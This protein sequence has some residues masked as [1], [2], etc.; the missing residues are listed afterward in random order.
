MEH[1]ITKAQG[2]KSQIKAEEKETNK[3]DAQSL[4]EL[5]E[6]LQLFRSFDPEKLSKAILL[7]TSVLYVLGLVT[8]N[9]YLFNFGLSEFSLLKAQYIYTG[10]L[11][12]ILP[13]VTVGCFIVISITIVGIDD[14]FFESFTDKLSNKVEIDK[15]SNELGIRLTRVKIARVLMF[16][17]IPFAIPYLISF[18]GQTLSWFNRLWLTVGLCVLA[19]LTSMFMLVTFTFVSNTS[20]LSRFTN[21]ISTFHIKVVYAMSGA[22][23]FVPAFI[24]YQGLMIE[25][26]YPY[27]PQQFGGGQPVQCQLQLKENFVKQANELGILFPQEGTLTSDIQIIFEGNNFYVLRLNDTRIIHLNKDVVI[28]IVVKK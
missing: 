18:G 20:L 25:Y 19:F 14:S 6:N 10:A 2:Q 13:A 26:V 16:I 21:R 28:G 8:V 22:I 15:S 12:A 24:W 4:N 3:P 27:V 11:I 7:V 17:I 5:S 1:Q 23:F 9:R